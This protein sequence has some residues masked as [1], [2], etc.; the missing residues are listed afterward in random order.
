MRDVQTVYG[1][2]LWLA[3]RESAFA[4]RARW[5]CEGVVTSAMC[6]AALLLLDP[7]G[8]CGGKDVVLLARVKCDRVRDWVC[9]TASR[10]AQQFAAAES[11]DC[12]EL[13]ALGR[14]RRTALKL[15][16]AQPVPRACARRFGPLP[17]H[18]SA[19]G[20]D[21]FTSNS[22]IKLDFIHH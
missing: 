4:K 8:A 20:H 12:N 15:C 9:S 5:K 14:A 10:A 6:P 21:A 3:L 16:L 2:R 22:R 1:R 11:G 7:V 19:C 18:K 13:A 17:A